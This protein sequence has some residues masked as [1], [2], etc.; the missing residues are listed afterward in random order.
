MLAANC[1]T[2]TASLRR[3]SVWVHHTVLFSTPVLS[4]YDAGPSLHSRGCVQ[5]C[6]A[7]LNFRIRSD[8]LVRTSRLFVLRCS[9]SD[10]TRESFGSRTFNHFPQGKT[11]CSA[12]QRLTWNEFLTLLLVQYVY[13]RYGNTF[14]SHMKG[15]C[16]V[17]GVRS[18]S[19]S[20]SV[21]SYL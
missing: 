11:R 1:Y 8:R 20:K 12:T 18:I 3:F 21:H 17:F 9:D 15:S 10:R 6:C 16:V 13:I 14:K 7:S 4:G 2:L 19:L 5:V